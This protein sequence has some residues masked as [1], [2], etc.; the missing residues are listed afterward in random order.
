MSAK[1]VAWAATPRARIIFSRIMS[2]RLSQ[3]EACSF[4]RSSA[5]RLH[6]EYFTA[7]RKYLGSPQY[8]M[9]TH[10]SDQA[11]NEWLALTSP[12]DWSS[13]KG[14]RHY[15]D[16][17]IQRGE[18][19]PRLRVRSSCHAWSTGLS[20][21]VVVNRTFPCDPK[22]LTVPPSAQSSPSAIHRVSPTLILPFPFSMA[23]ITTKVFPI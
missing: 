19:E 21:A 10:I 17:P 5:H 2:L 22:T 8:F 1:K 6:G 15:T 16:G 3:C 4:F 20:R 13:L 23:S 11:R 14:E 7:G 9:R 12:I 18:S